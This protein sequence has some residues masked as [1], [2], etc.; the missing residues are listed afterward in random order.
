[1]NGMSMLIL[2][3]RKFELKLYDTI[4]NLETKAFIISYELKSIHGGFWVK[5]VKRGKLFS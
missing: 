4:N 2:T 5:S 1:V 3:P